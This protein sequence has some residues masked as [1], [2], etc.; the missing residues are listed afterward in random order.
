MPANDTDP[1]AMDDSA[2]KRAKDRKKK[3]E[4]ELKKIFSDNKTGRYGPG[5]DA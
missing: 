3:Q 4:E 2:T 1:G 5:V